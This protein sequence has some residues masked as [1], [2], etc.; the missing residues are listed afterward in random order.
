MP[1][2]NP[3]TMAEYRSYGAALA[4]LGPKDR[5]QLLVE[6]GERGRADLHFFAA[7]VQGVTCM[8]PAD[9]LHGRVCQFIG[10]PDGAQRRWLEIFRG[11]LKSTLGTVAANVQAVV[12]DPEARCLIMSATQPLSKS[13]LRE[14]K[15]VVKGKV[16]RVIYPDFT[17]SKEQWNDEESSVLYQGKRMA[18]EAS[19]KAASIETGV[20]GGHFS[21]ITYDDL[22]I[23]E[24][25]E[26]REMAVR[27]IDKFRKL[28]PLQDAWDTPQ[29]MIGT[30][31]TDYD[32]YAWLK[33]TRAKQWK[34][35]SVPLVDEA[36][37]SRWPEEF[38]A[39]VL[40]ELREDPEVFWSQYMLNP[41]P[42]E[43]QCFRHEYV[44]HYRRV[45]EDEWDSS[46]VPVDVGSLTKYL[47]VDPAVGLKSRD[48]TALC[49][50]G[51]DAFGNCY[52]LEMLHGQMDVAQMVDMTFALWKQYECARVVVEMA[53]PFASLEQSF[54]AEM[55]ARNEYPLLEK[56]DVGNQQKTKR[57]QLILEPMYKN[58]K[59]FHH[60]GMKLGP[61]EQQL[62]DFPGGQ[63]DDMVDAW[64]YAVAAARKYGHYGAAPVEEARRR[65]N[66]F[67]GTYP[68]LGYT[69]EELEKMTPEAYE[70]LHGAVNSSG[71]Y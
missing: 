51:V 55:R 19:W 44:R 67:F 29:V 9:G 39:D 30:P 63:H 52:V 50:V 38:S 21:R 53:G 5:A 70:A 56:A 15:Q 8:T 10:D 25:V 28:R 48:E 20:T 37:L 71:I 22:V 58:G 3:Q 24:N 54:A 13:F 61:F 31:Y 1:R 66:S 59:L 18:R 35:M 65:M 7:V 6:M 69:L 60:R 64:A 34:R 41:R 46:E 17:P 68:R 12:R 33:R 23:P 32:L 4:K 36:G 57:V 14:I 49:V 45:D 27:V 40:D 42:P 2:P 43:L 16:F 47:A 11:A 26:T 62:M